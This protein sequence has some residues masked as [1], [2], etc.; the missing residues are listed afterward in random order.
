LQSQVTSTKIQSSGK[1]E[2]HYRMTETQATGEAF[3]TAFQALRPVEKQAVFERLLKDKA[4]RQDLQD[5][6]TIASRK[7]EPA[8]PLRKHFRRKKCA[9]RG[10]KPSRGNK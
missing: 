5:L 7:D 10:A 4:L 1:I 3:W 2:L 8:R 6:A 9:R